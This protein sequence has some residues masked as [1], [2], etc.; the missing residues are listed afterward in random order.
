MLDAQHSTFAIVVS[1]PQTRDANVTVSAATGAPITT[2]VPA[3]QVV[4]IKPQPA[5]ADQPVPG[6]G[7]YKVAYKIVSDLPIVA[8][9][10]NPLDNQNVFSNDA[11][12]LL[13]STAYDT[14][15]YAISWPTLDRRTPAPGKDPY[16]GYI[17]IV[18]WQDGTQISV[19]PSAAVVGS[20]T[21]AGIAAGTATT[22]TLNAYD[23]LNIEAAGSG[24]LTGTLITSPNSVPYGV[25]GGH[26]A[27]A[28]GESTS[29]N[30]QYP[31]GPCCADHLEHMLFPNST[32]GMNFAI[33]RSKQRTNEPD[34]LRVIAQKANTTVTFT[35]APAA[36]VAGNC[37]ALQPGQF[38]D[39]KIQTDTEVSS[40]QPIQIGH[41]LESSIWGDATNTTFIGNGDP[42]MEIAVPIEQYRTDYT[43]LTPNTY[44]EDYLS[45]SAAATGAVTVDGAA[46]TLNAFPA[47]ATHRSAIVPVMAGTHTIH[48]PDGCGVL[49]YGYS[50]AVSYMYAGGLDLKQIVIQ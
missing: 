24:D 20:A 3:G 29:P 16:Y 37:A 19:T 48:C 13:P 8:Y 5:I 23:V 1:N 33:A 15:Y 50:D 6:T 40:S 25:F 10:F 11:S 38:C 21:M 2:V 14:S 28:F 41:F 36:M 46:I 43:V 49:V 22:F 27:S 7:Q 32:W 9:Q 39:V 17:S 35:P 4:A 18:A 30:A 12:L 26:E 44:T 31:N 45:I 42:S 34:Y 47:P